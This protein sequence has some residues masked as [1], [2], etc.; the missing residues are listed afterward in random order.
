MEHEPFVSVVTP[1]YNTAPYIAECIESVLGQGYSNFEYLLVN[2]K[3][4]DA[5]RDIAHR[6]A[7]RDPRIKLFDNTE[8]LDQT[9]NFNG[10]LERIS[11]ASKYVKMALADDLIFPTCLSS[12][13]G[14]AESEPS[15]AIVSAYRIWGDQLDQPGVPLKVSRLA[16]R[17]ACR[18]ML[19]DGVP[20]TGSQNTV[21]YRADVVR[22][23]RPFYAPDRYFA[24]CDAAIEIL[25]EHDLG[26]VHQVLSFT[27]TEND[28]LWGR[29]QSWDP[30]LLNRVLALEQYG[31]EVL[32]A[33]EF[34]G[35]RAHA[36]REYLSAL[37]R[38]SLRMPG[39]QFWEY[40]RAGLALLGWKLDWLD[41]LPWTIAEVLHVV[42]NPEN[43]LR[44]ALRRRWRGSRLLATKQ[45]TAVQRDR[46]KNGARIG[47]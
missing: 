31:G 29:S 25:L 24:D 9:R 16:G 20:L 19:L 7:A 23:R 12:M 17:E 15:V 27:R 47:I 32:S 2:N 38:R 39:R 33:D 11:P 26:F 41:V 6:Y 21:L 43:T 14:L 3:S 8:F 28:S 10:A 36:R 5:S 1:Y 42:L 46:A 4:T 44:R 34:D 45:R 40:H 30:L 22:D 35:A 18:R 37:G 13:V